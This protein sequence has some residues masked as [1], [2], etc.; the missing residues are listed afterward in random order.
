MDISRRAKN[1]NGRAILIPERDV[2]VNHSD[3]SNL[4]NN[5]I[6]LILTEIHFTTYKFDFSMN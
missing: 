3:E 5:K 6:I 4:N 2:R 1:R